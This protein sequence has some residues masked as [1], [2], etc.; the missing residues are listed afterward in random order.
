MRVSEESKSRDP[1]ARALFTP[2]FRPRV[3]ADKR[4]RK[5]RKAKHRKRSVE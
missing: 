4:R 1:I 5:G 3:V 2:A